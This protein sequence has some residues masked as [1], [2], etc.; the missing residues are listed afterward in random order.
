ME[1]NNNLESSQVNGSKPYKCPQLIR[2]GA[3]ESEGMA[4]T[5]VSK[6]PIGGESLPPASGAVPSPPTGS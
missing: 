2:I 3:D 6:F 5:G 4:S 1:K